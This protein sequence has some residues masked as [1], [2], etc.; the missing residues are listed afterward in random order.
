[1]E[2]WG[3][4]TKY[5]QEAFLVR[6]AERGSHEQAS[7]NTSGSL[8]SSFPVPACEVSFA[9]LT[10]FLPANHDAAFVSCRP[11]RRY[12]PTT[13]WASGI[14]SL[15]THEFLGTPRTPDHSPTNPG[16][17]E[18]RRVCHHHEHRRVH[19]CRIDMFCF[20]CVDCMAAG[21]LSPLFQ[22]HHD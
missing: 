8:G 5:F 20:G 19:H 13:P 21:W 22:G 15:Y 16:K 17:L 10:I 14:P 6:R 11:S 2:V 4:G 9:E 7:L 3:P 18:H 12:P 1:M